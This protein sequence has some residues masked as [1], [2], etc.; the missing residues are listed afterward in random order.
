MGAEEASDPT[1]APNG[2]GAAAILAAGVGAFMLS[3]FAIAADHIPWI[4]SMMTFYTPTGPLAGVTTSA[5]VIWLVVW[6][7]L[8]TR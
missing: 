8:D 1:P 6:L 3:V 7:V 5:I 2:S 4:K